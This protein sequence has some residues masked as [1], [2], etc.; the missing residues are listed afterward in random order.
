MTLEEVKIEASKLGYNL[1]PKKPKPIPK[2]PCICGRKYISK[3]YAGSF[4]YTTI[5][6]KCP[7]CGRATDFYKTDN[8]ARAAWN[9]MIMEEVEK[10]DDF[11]QYSEKKLKNL[12]PEPFCPFIFSG[13]CNDAYSD[14]CRTCE[15][16][17]KDYLY[18]NK[19]V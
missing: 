16:A 3:W 4:G 12:S 18:I 5:G 8:V 10:L 7:K 1:V 13:Y 14:R 9:G 2:L 15:E 17:I 11:K 6:Y 19:L